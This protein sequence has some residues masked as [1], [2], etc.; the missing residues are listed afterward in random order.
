MSSNAME[1]QNPYKC[2]SQIRFMVHLLLFIVSPR[3]C[4]VVS[5]S[6]VYKSHRRV[7]VSAGEPEMELQDTKNVSVQSFATICNEIE[8][9]I[10]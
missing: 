1:N 5:V 6:V 7:C 4:Y 3:G 9:V 8:I 10:Q 2:H